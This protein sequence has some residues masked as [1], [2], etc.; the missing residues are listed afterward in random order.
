MAV[1]SSGQLGA[2][3]DNRRILI[4]RRDSEQLRHTRVKFPTIRATVGG[5]PQ[6]PAEQA[7]EHDLIARSRT[8]SFSRFK[9]QGT[10]VFVEYGVIT[11][12]QLLALSRNRYSTRQAQGR[13]QDGGVKDGFDA[14][15]G[16][17]DLRAARR[18]FRR[19]Q[20]W[21]ARTETPR[22]RLG[23]QWTAH[24]RRQLGAVGRARAHAIGRCQRDGTGGGIIA[25][26]GQRD[27]DAFSEEARGTFG[28][29][30]SGIEL[31]VKSSGQLCAGGHDGRI[32]IRRCDSEQLWHASLKL[33]SI[34]ATV[35]DG[36][37]RAPEQATE[38]DLIARSRTQTFCRFKSQ[39]TGVFVEHRVIT[40]VQ[41][42]ALSRNRHTTRQ[43]QG[44]HQDGG[45]KDGF[46]ATV[47]GD[48]LRAARRRCRRDQLRHTGAEGPCV[49]I[50]GAVARQ[51][52]H[53]G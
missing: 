10:G 12:V 11:K 3:Y 22:D 20:Q 46:D 53:R 36:P 30:G 25:G 40:K 15:V 28:S 2:G 43:L 44:R 4:R 17:D 1:K 31:A 49:S 52:C 47:G 13:H 21:H 5:G 23:R 6:W 42:L 18:G 45:V 32:L 9:T 19:D 16:S 29:H 7:T 26:A 51:I 38:H 34:R 33:P 39:A 35:G 14:T 24:I 41:L 37:Q 50:G 27:L 48:D 8:Q